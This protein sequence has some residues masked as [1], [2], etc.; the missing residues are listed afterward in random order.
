[1]KLSKYIFTLMSLSLIT[2]VGCGSAEE[3]VEQT[4]EKVVSTN[5]DQVQTTEKEITEEPARDL[6]GLNVTIATW[7]EVIEPEV[8]S[9]AY[10]E[11]LW[12]YRH[13][14]M[15]KHNFTFEEKALAKWNTTLELMSTSVIAGEPAAEIFHISSKYVTAAMVN[16]LCYDLST[17][18]ELD[19]D[20]WKWDVAVIDYM[21]MHGST[22]GIAIDQ[23][24][25]GFVYFNKRLFEEA[26]LDGDLP[27]DLQASGEWTWAAFEE[28][29]DQLT[30]DLDGDGINDTYAINN[31][32]R[33]F[34]YALISN[35][36]QMVEID[37]NRMFLNNINTPENIEAF[38]WVAD[39]LAKDYDLAPSHGS[40]Q[41]EL[42]ITGKVAMMPH[43]KSRGLT[44]QDMEDDWGMVIFPK[45]P[46]ADDYTVTGTGA[47]WF[48][49]STYSP[50]EAAD[51][52]FALN[53]WTNEPP[54]YD[55]EDDWM[56]EEYKNFRDD[57]A[58][59]ETLAKVREPG[60]MILNYRFQIPG[61][62][63][64]GNIYRAIMSNSKT[65]VEAFE[66]AVGEYDAVISAANTNHGLK[67][68]E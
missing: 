57:R 33:I 32:T 16:G 59:E 41:E 44:L 3:K 11:A 21:T 64:D 58:V 12:E 17:L 28:I 47:G 4:E 40:G 55:A 8:K 45:G 36:G 29:S 62:V 52:A 9:S 34:D 19:F 51:I 26:G 35:G 14:M 66:H 60:V 48:I 6:G 38:T 56:M 63:P 65:P 46:K 7:V 24:P 23:A 5:T 15:E 42:F 25:D 30:K 18:D 61:G 67:A 54:G 37:E 31:H 1:M 10:E 13:E 27:Y 39:Y 43:S 68:T 53:I 49:P 50:E 22:Y 20:H 2:L